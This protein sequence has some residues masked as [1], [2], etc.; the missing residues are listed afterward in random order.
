MAVRSAF[1]ISVL[2]SI[3]A[4]GSEDAPNLPP[5]AA[6]DF[7][8]VDE[9]TPIVIDVRANDTDPDSETLRVVRATAEGHETSIQD[10]LVHVSTEPNWNGSIDVTY[11]ISDGI[12]SAAGHALVTV[13]PVNDAPSA[14]TTAVATGRNQAKLFHL[15]AADVDGDTITFEIETSPAHGTLTGT[16]PD[17]TYTPATGYVG[18][19]AFTFHVRDAASSSPPATVAISVLTGSR[20]VAT[21]LNV[22]TAEDTSTTLTLAATDVDGDPI[23]FTLTQQPAFGTLTGTPP[24]LTYLPSANFHGVDRF[25]FMVSDGLLSSN[26]ANVIINVTA[27][28]DAPVAQAQTITATEDQPANVML[29]GSDIDGDGLGYFIVDAPARGTASLSGA[30]VVYRPNANLNGTDTFT[31]RVSDGALTSAPATVTV[32]VAPVADAPLATAQSVDAFED[33]PRAITLTGIDFDGDALTYAIAMGPQH[34]TLSGTP[35]AVTYTPA[36]NYNGPDQFTFAVSDGVSTSPSVAVSL[37]VAPV[38][39]AP[40]I[41]GAA[42]SGNE[43]ENIPLALPATDIDGDVLTY[44]VATAPAKGSINGSGATLSYNSADGNGNFTFALT[45]SDGHSTSAPATFT[46]AVAPVADAPLATDDIGI[47]TPDQSLRLSVL[48]NDSDVDGDTMSLQSVGTPLHGTVTMDGDD[49]AYKTTPGNTASDKFTYTIADSTGFTSTATVYIGIGELPT[50]MPVRFVDNVVDANFSQFLQQDI[51]RDGRYVAFTTK[52]A[53]T[54]GDTNGASDV[55]LFDRITNVRE[56]ISVPTGG[57]VADGAS[58]RPSISADGRYIA[59]A[60]A[61]TNLVANDS[62]GTVDVFVRDRVAGTTKR[63]SVSSTGAQVSGTSRDPD[64]SADGSLVAFA[65][66]AFQ[67]V[68]NDANGASD[69]FV[70]DLENETTTRVSIRVDGGEADQAS[71]MPVLSDDGNIVAF[72]SASSNLV[73]GDTN[74]KADVFVHDLS[75]NTTERVSVSST[76]IEANAAS[77]GRPALSSDGRFV[78]FSSGSTNLVPGSTTSGTYVRDRQALTTVSGGG[79]TSSVWLSGDG[80][81]LV[82]HSGSQAFVRDRFAGQSVNLSASQLYFPVISANGRYIAVLSGANLD[83]ATHSAGTKLYIMPNPL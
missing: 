3:T 24:N 55:Y 61:A 19:D 16:A 74:G 48:A 80:R 8:T 27:Q 42:L 64:I 39:D 44:T 34:G 81:Y 6:P 58:D 69:I 65:S 49:V 62:N 10:G 21:P 83:G 7:V 18:D 4:C 57:G 50:G 36:A 46:V 79:A 73:P 17:L 47:A 31:Y 5:V 51:S 15:D 12:V 25:E 40:T 53:L 76:G 41:A 56:R 72:V 45:A 54:S 28:N 77:T 33:A 30:T 37:T 38:D 43:G 82:G 68:P 26:P 20:P 35:P 63:V 67:L 32:N 1:A 59:F 14:R 60:S 2:L 11:R 70:R 13:T 23:T 78:A 66:N 71:V 29:A 9:D 52:S 22:S 75:S